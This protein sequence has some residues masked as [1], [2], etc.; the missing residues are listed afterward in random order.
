MRIHESKA[1]AD[2]FHKGLHARPRV[3]RD[4]PD[5]TMSTRRNCPTR[6]PH[7]LIEPRL[8]KSNRRDL[9]IDGRH[10]ADSGIVTEQVAHFPRYRGAGVCCQKKK[11]IIHGPT[12]IILCTSGLTISSGPRRQPS[13]VSQ[14]RDHATTKKEPHKFALF[15][16][17]K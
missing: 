16:V 4:G 13:L 14:E 11:D 8:L 15:K 7:G 17:S 1:K 10:P 9:P 2:A 6:V 5:Q 12:R 3:P